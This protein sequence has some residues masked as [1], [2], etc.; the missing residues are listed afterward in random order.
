MV[1]LERVVPPDLSRD[2][3]AADRDFKNLIGTITSQMHDVA[4]EAG[5][6]AI[7]QILVLGPWRL[8]PSEEVAVDSQVAELTIVWG[9]QL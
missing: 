3:A 5:Y 8:D 2:D 7:D 1:R 4:N 6:L 9:G